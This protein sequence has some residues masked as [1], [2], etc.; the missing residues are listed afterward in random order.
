MKLF[1]ILLINTAIFIGMVAS[2]ELSLNIAKYIKDKYRDAESVT[3]NTI[4]T[5]KTIPTN[6]E[7][8]FCLLL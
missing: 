7:Q 4:K 8:V 1:K 5:D 6:W 2:V 3:S